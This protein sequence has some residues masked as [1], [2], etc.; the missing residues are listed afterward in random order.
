MAAIKF[1]SLPFALT[2]LPCSSLATAPKVFS[3]DFFKEQVLALE[4]IKALRRR[5]VDLSLS[6]SASVLQSK[7]DTS[8]LDNSFESGY[9]TLDTVGLRGISMDGVQVGVAE[10]G[11]AVSNGGPEYT[12][13]VGSLVV[14]PAAASSSSLLFGGVDTEKHSG[15]LV[16]LPISGLPDPSLHDLEVQFTSLTISDSSGTSSLT[17]PDMVLS[18]CLDSGTTQMLL[19]NSIVEQIIQYTGAVEGFFP[20]NLS[21]R[22]TILTFGFGGKDGARISVPMSE[23]IM[24][25]VGDTFFAD[26]TEACELGVWGQPASEEVILGDTFLRSACVVYNLDAK[27]IGFAHAKWDAGSASNFVEIDKEN[28]MPER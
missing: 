11:S 19:H 14:F 7:L 18:A 26:G 22:D 21:T 4:N 12:N 15:S 6:S 16:N 9:F 23:L 1:T 27:R 25:Y 28:P 5:G 2:L 3:L 17:P 10:K 8:Y 13:I 24:S 20:C